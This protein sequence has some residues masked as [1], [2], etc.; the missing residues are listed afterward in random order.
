MLIVSLIAKMTSW[1]KLSN[2]EG[3]VDHPASLRNKFSCGRMQKSVNSV[4][5][6][7]VP[8]SEMS[9]ADRKSNDGPVSGEDSTR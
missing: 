1:L 6:F 3:P 8:N 4:P 9:T 5:D 2:N 7:G